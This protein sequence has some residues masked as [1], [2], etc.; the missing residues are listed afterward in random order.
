MTITNFEK[1][2]PNDNKMEYCDY[3]VRVTKDDYFA[4]AQRC[5]AY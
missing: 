3:F 5:L 2:I 4:E 1:N